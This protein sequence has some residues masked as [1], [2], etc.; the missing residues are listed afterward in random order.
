MEPFAGIMHLPAT[1]IEL[2]SS[3]RFG[4]RC[5]GCFG[6]L[7]KTRWHRAILERLNSMMQLIFQMIRKALGGCTVRKGAQF[8]RWRGTSNSLAVTPSGRTPRLRTVV[9]PGREE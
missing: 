3:H 5:A 8:W 4:V 7:T 2:A 6:N 1:N 9:A